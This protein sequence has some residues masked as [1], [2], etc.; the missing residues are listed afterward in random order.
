MIE[1]GID[2]RKV[3]WWFCGEP[4]QPEFSQEE[5]SRDRDYRPVCAI[6]LLSLMAGMLINIIM[7]PLL[8]S[9]VSLL[10]LSIMPYQLF[11]FGGCMLALVPMI[12]RMGFK[13][14][15]NIPANP[16]K[17]SS[18]LGASL[19]F[20]LLIYPIIY[21]LNGISVY[22]CRLLNIETSVQTFET[23]G[24]NGGT[25]YWIVSGISTIILAPI[26]EE[27]LIRLVLF[28]CLRSICPLWAELLASAIFGLMHGHPQYMLSLAFVGLCLQRA[29]AQGGLPRSILLHSLYNLLAF[30]MLLIHV[31]G[32]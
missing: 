17:P 31:K 22:F 14:S 23:L 2:W 11:A 16:E 15:M 32:Q 30:S 3:L 7:R 13:A 29:R 19:R 21:L 26:T 20:L 28:R 6:G 25:M 9:S 27:V 4:S 5:S 1:S 8:S 24:T 18:M 12:L 10:L